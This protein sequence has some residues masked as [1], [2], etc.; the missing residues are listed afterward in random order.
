MSSGESWFDEKAGPLVRPYTL[1]RGRTRSANAELNM[2]TLVVTTG[3]GMGGHVLEPEHI[4]ILR[5]CE[6]PLSVAELG[7]KL[8]LPIAVVKVLLSDLIEQN[9]VIFRSPPPQ[10]SRPNQK[11]LQAVLD[12]IR[13]L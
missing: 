10:V 8:N 12:G 13:R 4:Q 11:L 7:A 9:L 6:R 2:I 5:L 3:C 1:T